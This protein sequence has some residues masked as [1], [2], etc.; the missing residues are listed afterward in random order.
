MTHYPSQFCGAPYPE[1]ECM[2]KLL[3]SYDCR[4]LRDCHSFLRPTKKLST[5]KNRQLFLDLSEVRSHFK[6][7]LKYFELNTNEN[8]YL[9]ICQEQSLKGN[10]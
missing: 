8:T 3:F 1:K 2:G 7:H 6:F 9:E 4:E 10:A 5:L